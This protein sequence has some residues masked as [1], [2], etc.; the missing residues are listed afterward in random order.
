M[1]VSVVRPALA[2]VLLEKCR[3]RAPLYD[4]EN[5]FC[6]E[7]F[8]DL[9]AAG[10]LLLPAPKEFGGAGLTLEQ[11]S[12]ETRRLAL[13][14]P[15]TALC[16]NMHNFWVGTAADL[17]R[18]GDRSC[19]WILEEAAAGEVFAAG[20]AEH[21]ND[22]PGLLSTAKAERVDGGWRITGR[23]SFG[24]LSP[25]WT[26]FGFHAMDTSDPAAPRIVHGFL[27][28]GTKGC[29][30]VE[31]WDVMGMRA[32]KSDDTVLEGAFVPDKYV[33][34]IVPA[35][36][37]GV[38][39][40]ILGFLTWALTGFANVYYA[41]GLRTREVLVEQLRTKTSIALT[42]PMI[43][44]PEIQH[45]VAEI[46][47]EL[48]SI[49]PHVEAIA[50]DWSRGLAGPDWFLR[51]FAM[52]YH[53]VEGA[54]RIVDRALDLSGGFGMFKKSELERLFRDA[55]AGR[56]HPANPALTHELVAKTALGINP[57]DQP[58]WG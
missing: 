6:Q 47:L 37:A 29:R 40:F 16:L 23:K 57:D 53:A 20:H 3:E 15:A 22:I 25:V 1:S 17:W 51:L 32:T 9:K 35:G 24:S 36:A 55:R 12:L 30:I 46:S 45:G 38:D 31:T 44:H 34:R 39:P 21:G 41:I 19:Q 42:R 58:R 28:R 33:A 5:R 27:P 4:R 11:A 10:Y 54:F 13:H 7:D 50:R 43:H 2:E 49:G 26:R 14:A 52:K 18:N 56:F 48:E 8:D